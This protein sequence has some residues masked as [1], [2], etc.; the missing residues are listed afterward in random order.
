MVSAQWIDDLLES[1]EVRY[2]ALPD[3][4]KENDNLSQDDDSDEKEESEEIKE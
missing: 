3:W 4:I 1:S 2:Q